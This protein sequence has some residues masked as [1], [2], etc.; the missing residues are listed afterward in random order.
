[1]EKIIVK[2]SCVIINNYNF[3]DCPKLERFFSVF[4]P[5][6]HSY[7]YVGIHYD[8]E[9]KRL[10]LPR[11]VDIWYIEQLLEVRAY[12]ERDNFT[13][14]D[15]YD[16]IM[17][18]SLPR[19]ED[20][21]TA[22]RFAT[23]KGEYT[24]T[25]RKSQLHINLTTGKGK[26]YVAIGTISILGIKSIIITFAKSILE[27]WKDCIMRYT[28]IKASEIFNI[29][30]SGAIFRLLQK[31]EVAIKKYK[32]F[33]VTHSTIKSYGD[34]YGWDKVT[35][36]FEKI[37]VGLKIYDEAHTNF[38]N[39]C[40]IDFYT[41]VYKSYYLTATPARS[42]TEENK[43][44]QTAFKNVLAI[45]LFHQ[46]SDPHTHYIAMQYNSRPDPQTISYCKNKYGLD[47]MKYTNYIVNNKNFQMM[48][49]VV[50]D[51]IFRKIVTKKEDKILIYIGTNQ[52]ISAFYQRIIEIFPFL[53]GNIGI[54]TS[55]VSDS[56]K[57]YALTRQVI[58]TTTKSAGAAI[59][60]KG[61]KCTLVLAEPFKSEVLAR[62][63]L[64]RTRDN[65]TYYIEVVDK[66]FRYCNKYFLDK[67]PIFSRYALDCEMLFVD[68]NY[69]NTNY[70]KIIQMV[71]WGIHPGSRTVLGLIKP[72]SINS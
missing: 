22:I 50:L 12:V 67:R 48:A 64:G 19:D 11:G 18:K 30:G 38:E 54:F 4:E 31:S 56:D 28:T 53:E 47:R 16:D 60:I 39:M 49:T 46:E 70:I 61:L 15:V 51:Y 33:L 36:L 69:L 13:P 45:D 59:D 3:G 62:Q 27:Q 23:G 21:K 58:L 41:T 2:N 9:N 25:Q 63:T 42:N 55:I 32:I 34:A 14:Y 1:M 35:E 24:E 65:D 5:T 40:M 66:G 8:A 17:I 52:A 71:R 26:T 10:Y 7:R 68:D 37:R 72:F 57:S 29:D 20:Q 43:I 6:T 44:Y